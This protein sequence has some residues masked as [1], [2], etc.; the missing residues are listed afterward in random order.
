MFVERVHDAVDV[1]LTQTV[2]GA[3]FTK[4]LG[5]IHHEDALS[6]GCTFLVQHDDASWDASPVKQIGRQTNDGLDHAT[7][8]QVLADST[9]GIAPEQDPVRQDDSALACGLDGAQ[10]VEQV[11]VVALLAWWDAIAVKPTVGVCVRR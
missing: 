10:N 7:L 8:D 5:R 2:L 1:L 3:I 9:L 4:A 6:G 11:G